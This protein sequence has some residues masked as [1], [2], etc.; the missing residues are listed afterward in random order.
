MKKKLQ[1]KHS[2]IIEQRKRIRRALYGGESEPLMWPGFPGY[3]DELKRIPHWKSV[4]KIK[5]ILTEP[6]EK[7]TKDED[8]K[9]LILGISLDA[10][11]EIILA[12]IELVVR[13][14]QEA[15]GGIKRRPK[16]TVTAEN[17]EILQK[18]I[19]GKTRSEIAE[20][21]FPDQFK[22]EKE[23]LSA[24]DY[25]KALTDEESAKRKVNRRIKEIKNIL[26]RGVI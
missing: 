6:G 2:K 23:N 11:L 10:P 9:D 7:P 17:L 16:R 1:T 19:E 3:E 21:V 13:G 25:D 15:K 26:W 20:T 24:Q 4:V 5:D 8:M 22:P 12:D 14:L 18:Y